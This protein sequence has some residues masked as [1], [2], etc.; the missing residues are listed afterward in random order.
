MNNDVKS[1]SPVQ[2]RNKVSFV[3]WDENV[4]FREDIKFLSSISDMGLRKQFRGLP[5]CRC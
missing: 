5:C 4:L 3:E 2:K 1:F